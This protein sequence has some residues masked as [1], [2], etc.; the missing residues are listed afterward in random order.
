MSR[1]WQNCDQSNFLSHANGL[2]LAMEESLSA[3]SHLKMRQGQHF[4]R[5]RLPAIIQI[6]WNW[7]LFQELHELQYS[8]WE[9][10]GKISECGLIVVEEMEVLAAIAG[11][12]LPGLQKKHCAVFQQML[13][14]LN[15]SARESAS[16]AS[17][18]NA[19]VDLRMDDAN[20]K[21]PRVTIQII[22]LTV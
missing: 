6:D 5:P 7:S 14:H 2:M 21:M 22:S 15:G 12:G 9:R 11:L 3:F 20:G 13:E 18:Y 16:I 8:S 17:R 1:A 4:I 19:H 10:L